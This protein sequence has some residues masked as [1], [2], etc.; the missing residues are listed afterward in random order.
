[1]ET[2]VFF[3]GIKQQILKCINEA[4]VEVVIAVAWFTDTSI[5]DALLKKIKEDGVKVWLLFYDDK[6]N[7][8]DLFVNL[9]KAGAKIRYSKILMHNKFC[10]IDR[11]VV[12]NGSYNWTQ[13]AARNNN[14]NIQISNNAEEL[15]THFLEEFRKLYE[16][17]LDYRSYVE[18]FS[19]LLKELQEHIE[20]IWLEYKEQYE[21]PRSYPAIMQIEAYKHADGFKNCLYL[22]RC[23]KDPDEYE[24]YEWVLKGTK[25][26]YVPIGRKM[27]ERPDYVDKEKVICYKLI[28]RQEDLDSF[29]RNLFDCICC[30]EDF[31]FER[32]L[33][34]EENMTWVLIP[35]S[36]KG[37]I[38]EGMLCTIKDMSVKDFN[39]YFIDAYFRIDED[40]YFVNVYNLYK[41]VWMYRAPH[42]K[43]LKYGYIY[44]KND[45]VVIENFHIKEDRRYREKYKTYTSPCPKG[46]KFR[47]IVLSRNFV[48]SPTFPTFDLRVEKM[49][50]LVQM[51]DNCIFNKE[52]RFVYIFKKDKLS[53]I[54]LPLDCI[55]IEYMDKYDRDRHVL[56]R[57]ES[58]HFLRGC[59]IID[60]LVYN[61]VGEDGK[62]ILG[63]DGY[64]E[65]EKN[66][67]LAS[68]VLDYFYYE[69]DNT[70]NEIIFY[71]LE[72]NEFKKMKSLNEIKRMVNDYN[73]RVEC[74]N[75]E[76]KRYRD[77]HPSVRPQSPSCDPI[78]Y[79]Y[80]KVVYNTVLHR[81]VSEE[82]L[83][84][85]VM[86]PVPYYYK[87]NSGNDPWN[88]SNSNCYIATM[89]YKDINHPKIDLLRNFRDTVLYNSNLGR[90][91]V[92][93]Y[94]KNSPSWVEF[95]KDKKIA[96]I[97]IK[98]VLD[99][100]VSCLKC[101][102]K[103]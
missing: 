91:F 47:C 49:E 32:E 65:Y 45:F 26:E 48:Q 95:L 62:F 4:Q 41:D 59:K 50:S 86:P 29:L 60:Y 33:V 89:V 36:Y 14:E 38:K 63:N 15:A 78:L 69:I 58:C 30:R 11:C 5:I 72:K 82:G 10:V 56:V 44:P 21:Y 84:K 18:D 88:K 28:R 9:F 2:K 79:G 37:D 46:K 77:A 96:N 42:R 85:V 25:R 19:V 55:P 64:E 8:K 22:S 6:A 23:Y 74:F 102:R 43:G 80:K 39:G 103:G 90:N 66:G 61:I 16:G 70:Q 3:S 97:C 1:M 53:K 57:R 93:Y 68:K 92:A 83:A 99:I 51:N 71:K 94:Y 76:I 13:N 73:K 54:S 34:D 40:E 52:D 81:V 27:R 67:F 20:K 87:H 24:R 100:F 35:K 17:A 101:L 31:A 98:F 75:E 12:I 7:K